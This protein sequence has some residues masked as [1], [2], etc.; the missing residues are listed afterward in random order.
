MVAKGEKG[1]EHVP[2][3]IAALTDKRQDNL[4][5]VNALRDQHVLTVGAGDNQVRL[6]PPLTV[7]EDEIDEAVAAIDAACAAVSAQLSPAS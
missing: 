7:T 6:L 4:E 5:T 2:E 3:L 1:S